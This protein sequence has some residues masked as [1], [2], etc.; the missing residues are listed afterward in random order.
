MSCNHEWLS[1]TQC[2]YMFC[3]VGVYMFVSAYHIRQVQNFGVE[4]TKTVI[5]YVRREMKR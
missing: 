2:S 1:S 3:I 5:F 4:V